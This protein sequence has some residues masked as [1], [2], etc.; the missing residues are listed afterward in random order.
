MYAMEIGTKVRIKSGNYTWPGQVG[1]IMSLDLAT[2]TIRVYFEKLIGCGTWCG[3][4]YD[5]DD[6]IEI[7]PKPIKIKKC[8]QWK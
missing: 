4:N 6:V 8:M 7:K 1:T 5:I 3:H 2:G